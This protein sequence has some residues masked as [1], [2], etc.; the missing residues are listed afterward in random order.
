MQF[1]GLVGDSRVAAEQA[2]LFLSVHDA[3]AR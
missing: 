3:R 2:I 1:R